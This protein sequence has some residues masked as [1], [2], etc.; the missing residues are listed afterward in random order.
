VTEPQGSWDWLEQAAKE[1][2]AVI[3]HLYAEG[4]SSI[5]DE[6]QPPAEHWPGETAAADAT[7][8]SP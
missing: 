8:T 4:R 3:D 2:R 6:R 5:A 7:G 1:A